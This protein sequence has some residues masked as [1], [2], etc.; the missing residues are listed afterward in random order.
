MPVITGG[1]GQPQ[2]SASGFRTGSIALVAITALS[3]HGAG[4]IP[5][6]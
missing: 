6:S 5:F 4:Q 2:K 1:G 3:T